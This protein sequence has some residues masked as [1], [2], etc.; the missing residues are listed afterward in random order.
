MPKSWREKLEGPGDL[1]KVVVLGE[2]EA[3][4]RKAQPGARMVV[5]AP[6]EVYALIERIPP[7]RLATLEVLRAALAKKHGADLACP[8]TTGI[9]VRVAAMASLEAGT[10]IPYW[11][12]LKKGGRVDERLPDAASLLEAEG[13]R[14]VRRGKGLRVADHEAHL[15]AP[16]ALL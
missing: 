16:E 8:L 6:R 14:L 11:R 3:R 12:V 15:V 9:F 10:P 5:P 13:F 2:A 4:R 1:P 7:G